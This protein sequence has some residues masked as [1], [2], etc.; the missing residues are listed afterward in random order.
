MPSASPHVLQHT[1]QEERT[2]PSTMTDST[3]FKLSVP[4][5]VLADLHE[6][7]ERTRLPKEIPGTG[8]ERGI[9]H[10]D[11]I[12]LVERWKNGYE[13]RRREAE[14]NKL[15][16]FTRLIDVDNFG[17]MNLHFLHQKSAVE[18]AIPLLFVHGCE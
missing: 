6:R 1:A 10:A 5:S 15:P 18:G 16:M 2:S 9:P 7:L 12:R 14:I 8:R 11:L 3:P 13:W 4:E 17:S